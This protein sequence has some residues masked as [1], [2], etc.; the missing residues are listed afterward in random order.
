M[1]FSPKKNRKTL[2]WFKLTVPDR[3]TNAGVEEDEEEQ[4]QDKKLELRGCS[5]RK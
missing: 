2:T 3:G 4:E 1:T 5:F